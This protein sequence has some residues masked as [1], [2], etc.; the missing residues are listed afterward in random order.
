M[1]KWGETLEELLLLIIFHAILSLFCHHA[2]F[3]DFFI[4]TS[5]K[6]K[7]MEMET[8]EG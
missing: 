3:Q 1:V 7:T 4:K 6:L 2:L 5:M 8:E